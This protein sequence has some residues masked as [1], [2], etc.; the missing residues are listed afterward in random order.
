[1]I[2]PPKSV[3]EMSVTGPAVVDAGTDITADLF[4]KKAPWFIVTVT[5]NALA[6]VP[7]IVIVAPL[8]VAV[9]DAVTTEYAND[10]L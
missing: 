8:R 5:L 10:A 6:V 1:M 4:M 3:T 9:P 2:P 7:V